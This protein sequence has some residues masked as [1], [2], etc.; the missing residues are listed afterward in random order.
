MTVPWRQSFS[1]QPQAPTCPSCLPARALRSPQHCPLEQWSFLCLSMAVSNTVSC[2]VLI[3]LEL[4]S[5]LADFIWTWSLD[6]MPAMCCC[7][8]PKAAC[9]ILSGPAA[10]CIPVILGSAWGGCGAEV[11]S[12]KLP[13]FWDDDV[14]MWT[15]ACFWLT[16]N[17]LSQ[18]HLVS[19]KP[20]QVCASQGRFVRRG[21]VKLA[22]GNWLVLRYITHIHIYITTLHI[23]DLPEN[24]MRKFLSCEKP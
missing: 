10:Y 3:V 18:R 17:C 20:R 2:A 5:R 9:L 7:C 22:H 19:K 14:K 13:S 23:H 4:S 12:S 16:A 1:I 8:I 15:G 24:R 11:V 21:L 6:T